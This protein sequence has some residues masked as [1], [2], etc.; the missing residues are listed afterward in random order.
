[1]KTRSLHAVSVVAYLLSVLLADYARGTEV[2]DSKIPTIAILDTAIDSSDPIF[3]NRIVYEACVTEWN[4]CPNGSS[5]MEGKGSAAIPREQML[6]NGFDH[7]S[8]MASIALSVSPKV[9]VVFVRIIGINSLGNR[10]FSGEA[11]I[12][13]ALDWVIRNHQK[14]QIQAVSL[15]QGHHSL[16]LLT[17][18]C[19]RT[20]ITE[21]K[22]LR[23]KELGIP[24]FASAGNNGDYSRLDWPACI[25][26]AISIGAA[27]TNKTIASYSNR[28]P[29]L[30]DFFAPGNKR[31]LG[32]GG[33]FIN[34][35]GTSV[36]TATAASV[37]AIVKSRFPEMTYDQ[38][39]AYLFNKSTPLF[40]SKNF[41]GV[42]VDPE[43]IFQ[44]L[45]PN[46]SLRS[47]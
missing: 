20:S 23:L 3:D 46:T 32:I 33:K 38:V 41:V 37:W 22:I 47:R 26:S 2:I 45:S 39:Y 44:S 17:D 4:S 21:N 1:M 34:T 14:L 30:M 13:E 29:N 16:R 36:S 10:N 18:Y 5:E 35:S 40:D 7:G 31:V 9:K 8:Q 28:D 25:P 19:P 42:L 43:T 12:Y 11:T 27:L 24:L 15:S 6:R